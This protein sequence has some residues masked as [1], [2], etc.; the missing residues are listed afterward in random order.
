MA[1]SFPVPPRPAMLP[2]PDLKGKISTVIGIL[3]MLTRFSPSPTDDDVVGFLRY[4]LQDSEIV[5]RA[6]ALWLSIRVTPPTPLS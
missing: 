1:R 2:L 3:E 4:L 6:Y 5:D